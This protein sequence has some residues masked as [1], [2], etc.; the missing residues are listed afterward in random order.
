MPPRLAGL[1]VLLLAVPCGAQQSAGD[2]GTVTI[3]LREGHPPIRIDPRAALGGALDGHNALDI[4]R[5][6]T[7]ANVGAMRSAGLGPIT[8]RLRTELA[9]EAWHWNP[10]GR[11]SD[12]GHAQGYWTSDTLAP[13][14]IVASY[15][16]RLPRRGNTRDQANDHGYSR[17]DDGDTLTFWKSDPYLDRRYTNEDDATHPQWIIVDLTR[18][19][20]LNAIRMRWGTPFATRYDVQ[21]WRGEDPPD[22]DENPDG[23]WQSFRHGRIDDASGADTTIRLD[24]RTVSA[25]YVRIRMLA[26]SDRAPPGSRDVRDGLGYAVRELYAGT[27]DSTG[28]LRDLIRHD[29]TNAGQTRMYV[30]ST[31]PWHRATDRD[32]NIEQPGFDRVFHSGLTRGMAALI[33][34]GL[35]YDTPENAAAELRFLRRRGYPVNR[36]ELGEEPD[37]QYVSPDDYAALYLLWADALRAVEPTIVLGGPSWQT[38]ETDRMMAWRNG[39]D[40]RPWLTRFVDYLRARGRLSDLGF[41]SFE[42]YPY[43]DVCAPVAPRLLASTRDL[44]AAMRA[45][46]AQGL[47]AH[48]PR[49]ITELGYSAFSGSA[50]VELPGALLDADA[51]AAFLSMG[52]ERAYLYGYE[53]SPL[54]RAPDCDSWGNNTLFVSGE[55]RHIRSRSAAYWAARM[56]THEW[57]PPAEGVL[58]LYPA[59]SSIRSAQGMALITAYAV[60]RPAGDWSVMLINKDPARAWAVRLRFA[61]NRASAATGL[62]EFS[63]IHQLS[64]AT[65][66]WHPQQRAGYAEPDGPPARVR[67]SEGGTIT[68]PPYSLTVVHFR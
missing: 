2:T 44:A 7:A 43:D 46:S 16:Y 63:D 25:R 42:W 52:G 4:A 22:I 41:F 19:R 34:A 40:E 57:L 14:P 29:T 66:V 45:L 54:E 30:S 67:A 37:G 5:I 36:I 48:V 35:L 1:L 3:F 38:M 26:S 9:D 18:R 58:E 20:A 50:E 28:A 47:P 56:M 11:W 62:G 23:A 15:G 53:P 39:S 24:D 32:E 10:R 12:A 31:D 13:E 65:Y 55:A 17:L 6:Y 61:A 51:A 64:A 8:Y 60:H 49:V 33:P 27:M 68:L 21:Y 59:A